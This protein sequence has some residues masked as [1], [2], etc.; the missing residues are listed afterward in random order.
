MPER[1]DPAFGGLTDSLQIELGIKKAGLGYQPVLTPQLEPGS[2]LEG[3]RPP[4][5]FEREKEPSKG[6][7]FRC[8][9]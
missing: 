1:V 9:A 6:H 2:K 4:K 3:Y 5:N 8:S 7:A